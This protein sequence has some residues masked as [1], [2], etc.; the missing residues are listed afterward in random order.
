LCC[1]LRG[2][3]FCFGRRGLGCDTESVKTDFHARPGLH[4]AA[5]SLELA[6]AAASLALA[7]A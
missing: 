5:A 7:S 2:L 3:G 6:A 1:R 4:T